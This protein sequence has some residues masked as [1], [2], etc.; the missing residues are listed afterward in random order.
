VAIGVLFGAVGAAIHLAITRWRASLATTR[1]AA[2]ALAAMPLGL[3]GLGVLV[4]AAA[5]V[6]PLAAWTTPI[7]IVAVRFAVLGRASR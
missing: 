1:G 2:A 6:S 5:L 3:F 4:F 7:G